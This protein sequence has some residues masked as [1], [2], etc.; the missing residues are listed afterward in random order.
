M[1]WGNDLDDVGSSQLSWQDCSAFCRTL[2]TCKF[3]TFDSTSGQCKRKTSDSGRT[4][5]N[6]K[7]SGLRLCGISGG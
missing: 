1:Y 4:V 2:E 5:Y 6:G 3:W 7:T